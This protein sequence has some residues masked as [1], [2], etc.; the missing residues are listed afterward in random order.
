MQTDPLPD[1]TEIIVHETGMGQ[2]SAGE[3]SKMARSLSVVPKTTS[4]PKYVSLFKIRIKKGIELECVDLIS[5]N[6]IGNFPCLSITKWS[7]GLY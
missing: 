4:T 6:L 2:E 7:F 1:I 5:Y 3:D